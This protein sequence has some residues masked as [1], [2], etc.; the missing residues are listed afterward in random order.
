MTSIFG[1]HDCSLDFWE[2]WTHFAKKKKKKMIYWSKGWKFIV[3][4]SDQRAKTRDGEI[5]A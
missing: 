3:G 4:E 1:G 2:H 5:M